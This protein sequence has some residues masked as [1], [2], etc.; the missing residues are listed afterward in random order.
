M[1]QKH[2]DYQ[3]VPYPQLR[4]LEAIAYRSVQ[5]KSMM[6][7]LLEV[8]V[9]RARA[10]LREYKAITGKSLSFT[11]FLLGDGGRHW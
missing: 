8:D 1:K 7:A 11:A 5:H 6:H 9:S 10:F 3:V 4:R 2:A